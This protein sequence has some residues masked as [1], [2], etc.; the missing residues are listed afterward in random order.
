ME[1][2]TPPGFLAA[3]SE[4]SA[5]MR[6]AGEAGSVGVISLVVLPDPAVLR[7]PLEH[8]RKFEREIDARLRARLRAQDSLFPIDGSEW[9]VVLP[10]LSSAAVLTLGMLRLEQAFIDTPVQLDGMALQAQV[11][12]GAAI[13]PDHGQD[14]FHL[15]QS[16]RIACLA[17]RRGASGSLIYESGMEHSSSGVALLERDLRAAF[18]G[19]NELELHLQPKVH[20][21]SGECRSAEALL[22]WRDSRGEWVPPP[23]VVSLIGRLGLRHRFNRWLFQRAAQTLHTLRLEGLEVHMSINLSATDLYDVEV[24]DL[25]EQALMTWGVRASSLCLEIT[26]TSMLDDTEGDGVA[27]VLK[28]L[29]LLGVSLSI[30]DFGTGFSGMSRLKRLSV[31]EVKIDR[32]FIVDLVSSARDRE[33]AASIIELSHRLG[34]HVTAEGVEHEQTAQ[35][36]AAMGCDYIQGFLYSRALALPDFIA[37]A[38]ARAGIAA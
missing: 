24:P 34:V 27:D 15:L 9:L 22:R 2:R 11:V 14:A 12:C 17:A 26:E 31:Q 30:D 25:I 28:R 10:R 1:S 38:R 5:S 6:S 18:S 3:L 7:L 36:L 21:P 37:W 33:I 19:G 29:R 23:V 13:S 35:M 20:V 32:S 16:A 4:L 8:A